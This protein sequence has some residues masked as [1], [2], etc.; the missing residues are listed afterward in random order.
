MFHNIVKMPYPFL[1][2]LLENKFAKEIF[3]FCFFLI[4]LNSLH[5]LEVVTVSCCIAAPFVE[6]KN[7]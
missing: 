2:N 3:F 1:S 4:S 7:S 5:A 6:D